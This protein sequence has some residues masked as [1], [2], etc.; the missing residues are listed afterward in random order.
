[1]SANNRSIPP[2]L[3]SAVLAQHL[4]GKSTHAIAAWLLAEHG[5]E[6]SY[7]SVARFLMATR[8]GAAVDHKAAINAA[9]AGGA[10]DDLGRLDVHARR[11]H[12]MALKQAD[13]G[14]LK[15]YRLTVEQLRKVAHTRLHF[16]GADAPD[17]DSTAYADA[18]RAVTSRLA[19]LVATS[20]ASG[21]VGEPDPPRD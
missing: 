3:E 10:L 20:A 18:A 4:A 8:K 16:S 15:G 14:D 2:A 19:R 17:D 12:E 11:L 13:E 21:V 7:R 6:V 1:M 9:A 5:L